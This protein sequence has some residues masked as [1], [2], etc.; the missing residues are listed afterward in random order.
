MVFQDMVIID[1]IFTYFKIWCIVDFYR[2]VWYFNN[3]QEPMFKIKDR[4][5]L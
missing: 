3:Y 5:H 1:M 4:H 2:Y